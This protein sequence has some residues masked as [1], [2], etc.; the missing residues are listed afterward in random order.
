MEQDPNYFANLMFFC[1]CISMLMCHSRLHPGSRMTICYTRTL[2]C[3]ALF[4]KYKKNLPEN[5]KRASTHKQVEAL[6]R[7][8][9]MEE[10]NNL[11]MS[12]R[13]YCM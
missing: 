4:R 2:M 3:L 11:E 7:N 5:E 9:D 10:I 6:N 12:I 1:K 8:K 13:G